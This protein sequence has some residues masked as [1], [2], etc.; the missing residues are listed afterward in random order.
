MCVGERSASKLSMPTALGGTRF[1]P[2][3][4][5]IGGTWHVEHCA[6]PSNSALPR[7]AAAGSN[8]PGGG[9][10][11][12]S[13]S[14]YAC[15]PGSLGVT[16]SGL[17]TTCPKPF[18]AATGNCWAL[19]S[20][21]SKNVPWPCISRTATNAFQYGIEP[22]PVQVCRLTP[23]R[24]KAG[25]ISAA[26]VFPLGWNAL[27]SRSS[28]AS[29][30]PGPH[31]LRTLCTVATLVF[32][33]FAIGCRFGANPMMAPTFRSRLAQPSSRWPMPGTREL[34]TVEWHSAHSMPTELRLPLLPKKPLTPITESSLRSF[35]VTA[36]SFRL[37]CPFLMACCSDLG[38]LFTSTF[39]PSE[40]AA[41]GL[42]PG[43]TP[44]FFAPAIA[45]LRCSM[46]PQKLW[47][48][49]V[50]KRK[51]CLPWL[52]SPRLA[53]FPWSWLAAL[54]PGL[55]L[56]FDAVSAPVSVIATSA[57][58]TLN[59]RGIAHLPRPR[60]VNVDRHPGV[61]RPPV[62]VL[63]SCEGAM[64]HLLL[65]MRMSLEACRP[66]AVMSMPRGGPTSVF[67]QMTEH[68]VADRQVGGVEGNEQ[69]QPSTDPRGG[70]VGEIRRRLRRRD[71]HRTH[72]REDEDRQRGLAGA[73]AH[74]EQAEEAAQRAQPGNTQ[75]GGEQEQR[76]RGTD[77]QPE[78]H[79]HDARRHDHEHD[80]LNERSG[81][82]AQVHRALVH[83]REQ[84]AL[85]R[86]V[87]RFVL[88]G[89]VAQL[90][91]G[92]QCGEPQQRRCR[93]GEE[94]PVRSQGEAE[95]EQHR[96]RERKDRAHRGPAAHLRPQI[97]GEDRLGGPH[98]HD[99]ATA[100]GV[101]TRPPSIVTSRST[102][103][104]GGASWL[105]TTTVWPPACAAIS[106]SS[107]TLRAS[108]SSAAYGSSSSTRAGARMRHRAR[109]SRWRMPCENLPTR[110]P[111]SS[112]SPTRPSTGPASCGS[113]SYRLQ[114]KR[115]FSAAV[116]SSYKRV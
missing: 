31:A 99:G 107:T 87:C 27:P 83:R 29:N 14:S 81:R 78:Q 1:Q 15:N 32:S 33:S 74:R 13:D 111:A 35:S 40:S 53:L 12:L 26:E 28:S 20:R 25:G 38:S 7:A 108:A 100:A 48:P 17:A 60:A 59:A 86:I 66:A 39:R 101:I 98:A 21:G 114:A 4:V 6:G 95:R 92:E 62:P 106:N 18:A 91:R 82:L 58:A 8:D 44:P 77:G 2:G 63:E 69:A 52:T 80:Q 115:R 113:R 10:G 73:A 43:P 97:L 72:E 34:S 65:P 46:P 23:A 84:Q 104:G 110:T 55:A 56:A 61:P 9:A 11:A 54:P 94:Q 112:S 67:E 22:Q 109:V 57:P 68:E 41:F 102:R 37:T 16:R 42:R 49:N 3:W 103:C 5:K 45:W 89:P 90:H 51:V 79:D 105:A 71:D 93:L 36:G 47:S 76:G 19:S 24:P 70:S 50:S 75:H 88:I 30:L 96:G 116:R 85:Q 64:F